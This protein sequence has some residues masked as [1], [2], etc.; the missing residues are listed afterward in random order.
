MMGMGRI[1]NRRKV[2][3]RGR[4]GRVRG[5]FKAEHDCCRSCGPGPGSGMESKGTK[6]VIYV[7]VCVWG[8]WLCDFSDW[9]SLPVYTDWSLLR[10]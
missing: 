8:L 6:K 7:P 1:F 10:V 5:G 3:G 4:V 2:V 9:L